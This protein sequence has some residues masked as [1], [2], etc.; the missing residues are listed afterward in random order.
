M[1]SYIFFS[2]FHSGTPT[3]S[4]LS[5]FKLSHSSLVFVHGFPVAPISI[6]VVSMTMVYIS[7]IFSSAVSNLCSSTYLPIFKFHTLCFSYSN[8]QL[9]SFLYLYVSINYFMKFNYN[10]VKSLSI[11]YNIYICTGSV[12]I[13]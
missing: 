8:I 3:I 1:S 4:L 5:H 11:N 6:Y 10:F 13:L 2:Y 12:F 9:E 7:Q